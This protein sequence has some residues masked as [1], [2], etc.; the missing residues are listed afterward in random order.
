[1]IEIT[2]VQGMSTA[3]TTNLGK[4]VFTVTQRNTSFKK[5]F[6]LKQGTLLLPTHLRNV[7]I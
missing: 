5:E 1:V 2:E 7:R 4:T 6:V 3:N